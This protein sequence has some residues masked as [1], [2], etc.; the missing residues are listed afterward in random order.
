MLLLFIFRSAF[1]HVI[2]CIVC[3]HL[4]L[5]FYSVGVIGCGLFLIL[6]TELSWLLAAKHAGAAVLNVLRLARSIWIIKLSSTIWCQ[7]WSTFIIY[8]TISSSSLWWMH[9]LIYSMCSLI[10]WNLFLYLLGL[11]KFF[12]LLAINLHS[13]SLEIAFHFKCYNEKL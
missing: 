4:S 8:K 2:N 12:S 13:Y 10:L 1:V 9:I 5:W 6:G 11:D 3:V 7:P